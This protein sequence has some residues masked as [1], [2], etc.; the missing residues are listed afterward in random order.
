MLKEGTLHVSVNDKSQKWNCQSSK[1]HNF[2]LIIFYSDAHLKLLFLLV[3]VNYVF[4]LIVLI[5]LYM[6]SF[7]QILINFFYKNPIT[8][9]RRK[10]CEV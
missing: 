5:K 7:L 4:T 9:L 6:F 2:V 1:I 3:K 10:V 8:L